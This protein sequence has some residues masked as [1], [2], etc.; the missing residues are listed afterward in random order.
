[1]RIALVDVAAERGGGGFSVLNDYLTFIQNNEF[2]LQHSWTVYSSVKLDVYSPNINNIVISDI[3]KGWIY[4][5]IWEKMK[6]KKEFEDRKI[7]LVISLQNTGCKKGNYKQITYFH[8]AILLD[9]DV[10]FSMLKKT[11]RKHAMRKIFLSAYTMTSLKSVDRVVVQTETMK[12]TMEQKNDKLNIDI[13]SPNVYIDEKYLCS[14]QYPIKGLIYP[15]NPNVYKHIEEI[16]SC[17]KKYHEWFIINKFSILL[18]VSGEENEYAKKIKQSISGLEDTIKLIGHQDRG[19][20]F[21]L[22]KEYGLLFSSEIESFP[23]PFIEAAYV[24]SP[25]VAADYPYANECIQFAQFGFLYI[26]K[27]IDS[28]M[29]M[30]EAASCVK[31]DNISRHFD[32][33]NSWLKMNKIIRELFSLSEV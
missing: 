14:A 28:M 18:T 24:G 19:R 30:I 9:N 1:M 21:E 12:N 17:V 16:V 15:T 13:I 23:L 26:Q 4:R 22:Y 11:Q 29:K 27:D 31:G 32:N 10:K 5:L 25:I 33:S 3:K 8:N 2:C 7:E 6:A 20:I